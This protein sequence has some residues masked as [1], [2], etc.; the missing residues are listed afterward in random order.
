MA[1]MSPAWSRKKPALAARA[2]LGATK[3]TIGTRRAQLGLR[4]LP[5]RLEQASGRVDLQHQ[6]RV[7]GVVRGVDLVDDPVRRDR[8]DVGIEHDD[9]YVR[10]LGRGSRRQGEAGDESHGQQAQCAHRRSQPTPGRRRGRD[11]RA[12]P[13]SRSG[14]TR[15]PTRAARAGGVA[16]ARSG[17][18]RPPRV[19]PS[20]HTRY[21]E[22]TLSAPGT[23]GLHVLP[24]QRA[25]FAFDLL[26]ARWATR[27]G[28][29]VEV[30]TRGELG[31]LV[32]LGPAGGRRRRA[33]QPRRAGLAPRQSAAAGARA[34]GRVGCAIA[35]VAADRSPLRPLRALA[36]GARS[37]VDRLARRVGRGRVDAAAPRRATPTPCAWSSCITPTRRTATRPATCRRSSARS[38]PTTCART[39]GTTLATTSWSTPTGASSR[40]APGA[41]T[42][43]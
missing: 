16:A 4:D 35:L 24:V 38:T 22:L 41:S 19:A 27:P 36:G 28:A 33:D 43:R 7:V 40:A 23:P 11:A 18:S 42:D 9:P 3:A 25:P 12:R 15:T 14:E 5:H 17:C 6:G 21:G 26:G 37:A 13:R 39:A 10:S 31:R 20:A 29:A 30:R 8:V 1:A 2:P 32:A 34:R